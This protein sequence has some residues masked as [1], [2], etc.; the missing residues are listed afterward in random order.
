MMTNRFKDPTCRILYLSMVIFKD[1]MEENAF[2]NVLH[3]TTFC[4]KL[5]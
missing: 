4:G 2:Q 1:A 5:F 3:V